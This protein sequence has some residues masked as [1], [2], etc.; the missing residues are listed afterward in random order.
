MDSTEAFTRLV[1]IM[2]RLRSPGGCPWD[3]EQ[4]L[5][6]LRPYLLEETYEVLDAMEAGDAREHCEELGDLLL[7]VVFQARVREEAG[8]FDIADVAQAI[9]DKLVR[10]HP[11]V[12]G[13]GSVVADDAATVVKN[14]SEIKAAEKAS[15]GTQRKSALDGV[16]AALPA[17]LRATR[18]GEKAAA[19]GFDWREAGG[20]LD[21]LDE[22]A[23]ELREAVA[24]GDRASIEAEMGDYLFTLVNAC[25]HLGIDAESALRGTTRRFEQ[26]F[27]VLEA[28]V[29]D[30][31]H[32]NLRALDDEALER[33]WQAAKRLLAGAS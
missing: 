7:Q 26:R 33:R 16:P 4:T 32:P 9:A 25:R 19:A 6:T 20:V 12:F 15:A 24:R 10:R 3:R 2:A 5:S 8:D 29:L 21:K 22:E 1:G 18:I 11:H 28:G 13:D 14:W 27:R 31:G 17:L 23:L 30:D